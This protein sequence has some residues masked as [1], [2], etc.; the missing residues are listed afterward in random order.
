M[1]EAGLQNP[2]MT[3]RKYMRGILLRV[4]KHLFATPLTNKRKCVEVQGIGGKNM[5][6]PGQASARRPRGEE[7]AV[8]VVVGET[9]RSANEHIKIAGRLPA[10]RSGHAVRLRIGGCAIAQGHSPNEGL[11]C[12]GAS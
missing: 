3:N 5:L 2:V 11:N 6:L 12:M 9:S 10:L 7:S 8:V 4:S 1:K